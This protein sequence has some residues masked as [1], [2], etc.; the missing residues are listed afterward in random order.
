MDYLHELFSKNTPED[1]RSALYYASR[2]IKQAE[3]FLQQ[4]KDVFDDDQRSA[5]NPTVRKLT[6]DVIEFIEK[7]EGLKAADFD[8]ELVVE[9]LDEI[10]ALEDELGLPPSEDESAAAAIFIGNLEKPK[11][12]EPP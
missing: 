9:L 1:C 5:P 3:D 11:S 4:R 10:T 6:L 2:Y 7:R 8:D 12:K